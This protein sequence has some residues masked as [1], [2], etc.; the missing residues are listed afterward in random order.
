M[1]SNSSYIV[2]DDRLIN[3]FH[4]DYRQHLKQIYS[5]KYVP[6]FFNNQSERKLSIIT[7]QVINRQEI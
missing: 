7:K 1:C 3:K 4:Y 5:S 6:L 2:N